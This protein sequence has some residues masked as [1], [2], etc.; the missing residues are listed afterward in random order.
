MQTTILTCDWCMAANGAKARPVY[1][2]AT[3]TLV[4]GR[5]KRKSPH[6]DLCTRHQRRLERLFLRGR[7][8]AER[9]AG[10][11]TRRTEKD[12]DAY[13]KRMKKAI[14]AGMTSSQPEGLLAIAKRAKLSHGTA[15]NTMRRL[16]A[17][18]LVRRTGS[19]G[20]SRW[21]TYTKVE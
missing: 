21:V 5:P 9:A 15:Y 1:A 20:P 4:N 2:V 12:W 7:E 17:D 6:V 11:P 16:I 13:W 18:K 14:L 10:H 3:L 8:R 19:K